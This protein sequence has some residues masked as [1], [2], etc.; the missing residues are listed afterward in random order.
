MNVVE[1]RE[2]EKGRRKTEKKQ[3]KVCD[4]RVAMVAVWYARRF[5]HRMLFK[6]KIYS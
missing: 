4:A 2:R 3:Q 1:E 5:L 6:Q